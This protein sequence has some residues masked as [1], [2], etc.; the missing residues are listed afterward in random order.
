MPDKFRNRIVGEGME[1]LDSVLFNPENWR[2][3]TEEQQDAIKGTVSEVGWVQRVMINMRTS[4]EWGADQNVKTLV[5][6]HARCTIAKR[7]G[8]EFI[9]AVYVDLNPT[10]EAIIIAT[11]DP[12]TG[13]AVADG[14]KLASLIKGIETDSELVNALMRGIIETERLDKFFENEDIQEDEPRIEEADKLLEIWHVTPGQVWEIPSVTVPGAVHRVACG[15]STSAELF[16]QLMAGDTA[17]MVW[18]D[19]P[20]GV[21]YNGKDFGDPNN[22]HYDSNRRPRKIAN[23]N[24]PAAELS[25]MIRTALT[26]C[27]AHCAEGAAVYMASPAGTMLP[28]LIESFDNSGFDY[29]WTLIWVKDAPVLSRGDY[30]MRHENIL[31][32]WRPGGS[33]YFTSD[34]KQNSV[35]EYPRPKKSDLHP[36][37]KPV[38]LVAHQIQNSSRKTDIVIDCFAGSGTT[39]VACEKTERLSRTMELEPKNV[40]VILQRAADLGLTPIPPDGSVFRVV[41]PQEES[42]NE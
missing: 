40:A 13:M 14:E 5:D 22:K 26:N 37:M 34:R 17:F 27:A 41:E 2:I 3:H 20:Y 25:V 7:A 31:Y 19:P 18:T 42:K 29:H 21:D 8:E 23:D 28:A 6:G 35:F 12:I 33:H 38:G 39:L 11:L 15:D 9:P 10:E 30:H 24:L 1:P 16:D 32:G 36:T 4:P